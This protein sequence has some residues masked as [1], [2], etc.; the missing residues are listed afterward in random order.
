MGHIGE[1]L[2][3]LL[4][5]PT[6]WILHKIF[7][8]NFIKQNNE[9]ADEQDGVYIKT[10]KFAMFLKPTHTQSTPQRQSPSTTA[11]QIWN[12]QNPTVKPN[13]KPMSHINPLTRD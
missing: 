9:I 12:K 10:S 11:S 5:T 4:Y 13:S 8:I 7:G 2:G 1:I 3:I 6:T